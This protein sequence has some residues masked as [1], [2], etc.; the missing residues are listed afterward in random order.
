VDRARSSS[1]CPERS[2]PG[3]ESVGWAPDREGVMSMMGGFRLLRPH[4]LAILEANPEGLVD[5]LF[6]QEPADESL[7]ERTDLD[8]DKAW[9]GIHFLLTEGE[10]AKSA[11]L[12]FLLGGR[13]VSD[14]D[15]GY[16]PARAFSNEELQSIVREIE[17]LTP[18]VLRT[19][20]EPRRMDAMEIY[21]D[22]WSRLTALENDQALGYLLRHYEQLKAFLTRGAKDGFAL[23]AFLS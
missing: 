17:P 6:P 3:C 18:D 9:H 2:T 19:R 12:Y 13:R 16:G 23:L 8:I 7:E 22:G 5:F 11:P 14:E 21:P 20:F 15:L 4:R 10:E 1:I